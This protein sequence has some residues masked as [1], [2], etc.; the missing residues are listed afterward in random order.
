MTKFVR[1][2][3]SIATALGVAG[4]VL[5]PTSPALAVQTPQDRLVSPIPVGWTPSAVD[6]SVQSII[7]VGNTILM[8][9]DFTQ[10][11]AAGS[12]T[13]ISRPDILA[14]DATTGAMST[15][16]LPQLDGEVEVIVPS[17]DGKSVYVGGQFHTVNGKAT[18]SLTQLSL[19]DGTTV[20]TFKTPSM[21]GKVH[22]LRLVGGN[23]WVA[24]S[25]TTIGGLAQTGLATVNPTTGKA[26]TYMQQ[27]VAGTWNGGTTTVAKIDVTP[28]GSKLVGIGNF[29]TVGGASRP[30]AFMLDLSGATAQLANWQT[31]FYTS[32]C[33]N[34]FDSYLRDLDISPDGSYMVISTTGAYGGQTSACDETSRWEMGSTGAA[35]TPTWTDYTGGDT[36]YA[37][38]IAG[39]AVYTGGHAR[40]QNNPF[41][42]DSPGQGA[43]SRPGIAALDPVNGLPFSWNPMRER[44]VGVF[45]LLATDQGLWVGS[46]T[47][48]IG[49]FIYHGKIAF[50]PLAGGEVVPP[51]TTGVLP[52]NVYLAGSAQPT[53]PNILYRVDAGGPALPSLDDG[54][55]W[56]EDDNA[57]TSTLHNTGGTA[58]SYSCCAARGA[59]LPDSAP[60]GLFNSE[61]TD[62]NGGNEMQWHFPVPAGQHVNVNLYFANRST[63]TTR[64]GQRTFDVT[65][66]STKVLTSYDV[67]ADAGNATGVMK[68]FPVTSDGTVDVTFGH[69]VN[70]P[71]ISGIEIVRTDG[72]TPP[73]PDTV[74]NV[75]FSGSSVLGYQT[76]PDTGIAWHSARGATMINGK[77]YYGFTDGQLYSRT[78]DG[79]T[80]G[81]AT[82]VNGMDQ[83]T[84]LTDFH[85][86]VPNITAM[87]FNGG[88]LYYTL[89]GDTHLYYRY[90]TP[91]SSMVGAIR[92]TASNG[93]TGMNFAS[94]SGMFVAGGKLYLATSNGNLQQSDF[95]GGVP[96]GTGTVISGPAID[97][98]NWSSRAMFLYAP[99][100]ST[101]TN[102]PPT[103]RMSVSCQDVVCSMT[104][105]GS[106]DPEGLLASYAWDFG[107]GTTSTEADPNHTYAT[108]GSYQVALKVTDAGGLSDTMT[109]T[110]QAGSTGP[111]IAFVGS[112]AAAGNATNLSVG[113]PAGVAA[114]NGMV[115]ITTVASDT[116]TSTAPAGWTQVGQTTSGKTTSTVWQ[117]V[118][119]DTDA[120]TNVKVT[121]SALVKSTV[122]LYAYSG[123]SATTPVLGLQGA[124]E[125][126]SRAAHTTPTLPISDNRTWALS[127]WAD[128][129]S[130]TTTWNLP[131]GVTSRSAACGAGGGHICSASAD[132]NGP[133]TGNQYGGQT[134]TADSVGAKAVMWTVL[135]AGASASNQPPTARLSV[136]CANLACSMTGDTSSDPEGPLASYAWDFGDG[137]SSSAANPS[138]VYAA[139]GTYTVTLK[140]TDSG[141]VSDTATK[142]VTVSA[143]G[144]TFVGS[145]QVQGN[146]LKQTVT[147]PTAISGGDGMV[148]V[149]TVA[150]DTVTASAPAGWAQVGQTT[151]GK[152]TSTIWQR[153]AV[154]GDAGSSVRVD[155][156]ATVKATVQLFAYDGTSA[157][158]PV[159]GFQG[160]GETVSQAGHTTPTVPVSDGRSWA[161]SYWADNSSA[162]TTWNLPAGVTSRSTVCGTGGGHICAAAADSN[163]AVSASQYGGLTATAD[164]TG[165]KVIMWTVILQPS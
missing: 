163:G 108:A 107:D 111:A 22:D 118:A 78:F 7:Q 152:T 132:S 46:D 17:A 82:P 83:I 134:A 122:S 92:F 67:V 142:S 127:Y 89:N 93:I 139:P 131:A 71:L 55:S 149:T 117:R 154:G 32:H 38:A 57:L 96:S 87:M 109:Q 79:T 8:G 103:A 165:A 113:V 1:I 5:L 85:T 129:S 155:Y 58:T 157:T 81:P 75:A 136:D 95:V 20:S 151:S 161:L 141:G 77:V 101:G 25:F 52:G 110:I 104:G 4:L 61:R 120:G 138:H 99:S 158:N 137:G 80:F 13:P 143:A 72:P 69:K 53:N 125:T 50:L 119:T 19:S 91:E 40:W 42:G 12:T 23:L 156:S 102:Q 144:I 26:T 18:K 43:V 28:D 36:T 94:A 27:Q 70:N 34:S 84:P 135:L 76:L 121:F 30:Q 164:S 41:K 90:F 54:P 115:L 31:N 100:G 88:R 73:N 56:A 64:A 128:N 105:D 39:D 49:D 2:L 59:T 68:S 66:D 14:F 162:T 147:I 48:Q 47:D 21:N 24:G 160:A 114:D 130:A 74:Q 9:G 106:S 45:D 148:L 51:T 33:S 159:A 60:T 63:S 98:T 124:G 146:A 126:V 44:G 150:S 3:L 15:T 123:T 37:V 35:L 11:E 97:S 62:P 16:F 140:V 65:L 6:G 133:V 10:V 145:D 86:D 29:T 112:N 116:V 153:V